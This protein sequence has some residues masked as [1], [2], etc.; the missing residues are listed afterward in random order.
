MNGHSLLV[1]VVGQIYSELPKL[2]IL[3]ISKNLLEAL[4]D[5]PAGL[6]SAPVFTGLTTLVLNRCGLSWATVSLLARQAAVHQ[7]SL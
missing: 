3:N 5:N 4:P 1:Q 7:R 6:S 2:R